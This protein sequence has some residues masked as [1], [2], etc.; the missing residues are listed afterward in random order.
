MMMLLGFHAAVQNRLEILN[1]TG[2]EHKKPE[3]PEEFTE[4]QASWAEQLHRQDHA[5]LPSPVA[6]LLLTHEH[7]STAATGSK[8]GSCTR[9]HQAT[10]GSIVEAP[11][12]LH[13]FHTLHSFLPHH[14]SHLVTLMNV[15][16]DL[17]T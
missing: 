9:K 17:S 6:G 3:E 14:P 16:T 10:C 1:E 15:F 8:P 2:Q 13:N 12:L 4:S 7:C 11:K 5:C